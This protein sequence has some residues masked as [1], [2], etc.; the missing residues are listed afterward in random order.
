VG[1]PPTQE[2]LDQLTAE[3][4]LLGLALAD[5][6]AGKPVEALRRLNEHRRLFS[7][8]IQGEEE[9]YLRVKTLLALTRRGDALAE[10]DRFS[11]GEL[12]RMQ[13]GPEMMT[14]KAELMIT[15]GRFAE[16]A[17]LFDELV[18]RSINPSLQERALFGRATCRRDLKDIDGARDDLRRYLAQFPSGRFSADARKMLGE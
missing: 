17:A 4:R 12:S 14:T 18:S 6:L 13:R 7:R 5:Q 8:P 1:G 15:S 11:N 2:R 16:A 10:L 9:V 3:S